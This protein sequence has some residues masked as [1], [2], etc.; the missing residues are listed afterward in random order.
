MPN[1]EQVGAMDD[2]DAN[3]F[4]RD[5]LGVAHRPHRLTTHGW[6]LVSVWSDGEIVDIT[7]GADFIMNAAVPFLQVVLGVTVT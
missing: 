4:A 5:R 7:A 6:I 2:T 3:P 1:D